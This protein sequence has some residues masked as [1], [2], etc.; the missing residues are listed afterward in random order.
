MLKKTLAAAGIAA[1]LILGGAAAASA[2]YPATAPVTAGDTTLTPGQSTVIT[3]TDLGDYDSVDFTIGGGTGASLASIVA[4]AT[5]GSQV[6]KPVVDGSASATFTA[7][8]VGTYVVTVS[9]GETAL[10]SVTIT[11]SAAA[12]AG[13]GTGSLPA[14]GGTVP[15]AAIWL[16]VGA[17]GLGG[18]AVAAVAARRR[19]QKN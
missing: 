7:N 18:I 15:A 13:S 11:V 19:T 4:A 16:G 3:A 5:S 1:V 2:D 17:I 9:G 6:T 10:G 14:T 8:A 12:G